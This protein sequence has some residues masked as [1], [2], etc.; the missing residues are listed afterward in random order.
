MFP[1]P[2]S[3][4]DALTSSKSEKLRSILDFTCGTMNCMCLNLEWHIVNIF[5]EIEEKENL[6]WESFKT[7]IYKKLQCRSF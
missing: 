5:F 6:S 3:T 1:P 7:I 4:L 2:I